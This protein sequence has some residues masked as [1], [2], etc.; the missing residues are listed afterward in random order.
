MATT[1][2]ELA[3]FCLD[4]AKLSSDD[5][6]YTVDHVVFL[7]NKT[8][9]ILLD[10]RYA[11]GKREIPD[12]N[13]QTLC[14]DLQET[15]K[16][17]GVPCIGT[18]LKSTEKLPDI[19][20]GNPLIYPKSYFTNSE[21][22]FI[23]KERFRYVG[24]NKWLK[25]IIYATEMNNHIYLRSA[26]PQY[27]YLQKVQL[28]GIF[29]DPTKAFELECDKNEEGKCDILEQEV[30]LEETLIEPLIELVGKILKANLYLAKDDDNNASDDQSRLATFI[31]R[32]VKSALQQQIDGQ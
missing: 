24:H 9:A 13:Y 4:N 31:A 29:E 10:Q 8:R 20:V 27:K 3:Y 22:T 7:I 2:R 5:S 1:Y 23:N 11:N 25:N 6:Y 28:R 15:E 26:N 17:E 12:S 18:V 21:I 19:L 16:I 14:L 32:N 30:P